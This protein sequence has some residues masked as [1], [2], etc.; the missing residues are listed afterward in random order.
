[1][2]RW[3]RWRGLIFFAGII[4]V[5]FFFWF[6]LVD[7]LVEKSVEKYGTDIVG[8]KVE[9]ENADVS[10]F[11]LKIELARLKVANPEKPMTN[12]VEVGRIGFSMNGLNLLRRKIIIDLM[13]LDEIKLN[14]PRKKNGAI[15]RKDSKESYSTSKKSAKKLELPSFRIPDVKTILEK[16]DLRCIELI[17]ALSDDIRAEKAKWQN[18]FKDLPDNAKFL[19]Y[20]K[21]IKA[22][23]SSRKEDLSGILAG[24][25]EA[26]TIR[27]DIIQDLQ[28]IKNI[29]KE[30]GLKM[31][32]LKK[33]MD[34]AVQAPFEDIRRLRDKYALSP[35]GFGNL[36]R[37]LLG[38]EI[39]DWIE[40]GLLWY[41]KLKP[42]LERVVKDK[43]KDP[44]V[45]KPIRGSGVKVVYQEQTPL[46]DFL[47]RQANTSVSLDM[48]I[49]AGKINNITTDQD[50][51]RKP[52]T[53]IFSGT[54]LTGAESVIID[55]A[56]DHIDFLQSRDSINL[57]LAGYRL[58]D[59][60]LS[61]RQTLPITIKDG[62]L[63]LEIVARIK[64]EVVDANITAGLKALK[65]LSSADES[66]DQLTKAIASAFSDS[67]DFTINAKISGV[68]DNYQ[69]QLGSDLDRVLK[70]TTVKI[71]K[72]RAESLE[73]ELKSAVLAKANLPAQNLKSSYN[74]FAVLGNELSGR[75]N[76]FNS[77]LDGLGIKNE[78]KGFGF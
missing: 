34:E 52:L 75:N 20:K 71:F 45:V 17:N 65:I 18:L 46:P 26:T 3:L 56:L 49:L 35:K 21:R 66:A 77:L 42:V 4:L 27:R 38:P 57:R 73:N 16:E 9:L 19:E 69:I 8:A 7:L 32:S 68:L 39:G 61:G 43:K 11:P 55:G 24:V 72:K 48:G 53:F 40:S 6:I 51:L 78:I 25:G 67:S 23:K 10:I 76:Q 14:T 59:V 62:L 47:I 22:V 60:K 50:I 2:K 15:N 36:S 31:V 37:L 64:G 74:E 54:E 12:A 5:F 63:D 33:R 29:Q 1:M 44:G 30:F 70:A 28:N 58:R 13:S 41:L